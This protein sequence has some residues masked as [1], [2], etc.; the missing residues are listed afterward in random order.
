[1][2]DVKCLDVVS[3]IKPLKAILFKVHSNQI[4]IKLAYNKLGYKKLPVI[5]N[6][7]ISFFSPK[8]TV[9][10][11]TNPVIT[12]S[13]Y[14]KC[15]WLVPRCSLQSSLTVLFRWQFNYSRNPV[16][17]LFACIISNLKSTMPNLRICNK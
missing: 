13:S 5:T 14:K 12:N 15:I 3:T 8:S 16:Y 17:L 1:M 11:L 10:T 7:S 9:T 6:N 4:A 2:I